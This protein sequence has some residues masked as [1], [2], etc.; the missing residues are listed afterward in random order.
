MDSHDQVNLGTLMMG[1]VVL[2]IASLPITL[3]TIPCDLQ[4]IY[5][6]RKT[7]SATLFSHGN[8]IDEA[9]IH[10]LLGF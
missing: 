5:I 2:A 8:L 10:Q 3:T 1:F 7:N 4:L 6:L 9:F